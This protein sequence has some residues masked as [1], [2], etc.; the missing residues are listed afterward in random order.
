M[1]TTLAVV[2]LDKDLPMPSR[3]HEGDAG[4]DLYSAIDVELA[5]GQRALVPT[6]IAV[7]IPYGM[8]GLI[9]PRSGLAARLGLSIVNTPGTIDAGY[10]GEIKVSLINLDPHQPITVR[11]GDRIAQLLVQRVELPELV[12]VSSFDEAGLADTSRGEGGYGSSGGHA[13]L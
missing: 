10:R 4:V 8:V 9:H 13:S 7:A 1:S 2:R 11:R 3:A 5:P 12:E 6:G